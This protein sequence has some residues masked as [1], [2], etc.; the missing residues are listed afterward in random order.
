MATGIGPTT[1]SHPIDEHKVKFE[2]GRWYTIVI[3][4]YE[5]EMVAQI[6]NMHLAFGGMKKLDREKSRIELISGGQ[7]AWFK[8]LKIWEALPDK[9]WP[10][11]REYLARKFKRKRS[12]E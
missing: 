4:V 10:A 7:W 9:R 8:D 11:K 6:D 3:E 1:K 5:N 2:P 12:Y